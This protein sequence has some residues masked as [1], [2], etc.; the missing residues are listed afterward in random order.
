MLT[1]KLPSLPIGKRTGKLPASALPAPMTTSARTSQVHSQPLPAVSMPTENRFVVSAPMPVQPAASLPMPTQH[2]TEAL[3]PWR[4]ERRTDSLKARPTVSL[5][6]GPTRQTDAIERMQTQIPLTP[7]PIPASS[8]LEEEEEISPF[9][10]SLPALPRQVVESTLEPVP[11][12]RVA[13]QSAPAPSGRN[14]WSYSGKQAVVRRE[15]QTRQE[16]NSAEKVE[17]H[18]SH[19]LWSYVR[20]A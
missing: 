12:Y 3:N 19:N 5:S 7:V 14:L 20:K 8:L 15:R 9:T 13:V 17:R 10:G 6:Q 18:P 1:G 2:D 11:V 16:E 4:I